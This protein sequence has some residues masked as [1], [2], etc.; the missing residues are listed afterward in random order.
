MVDERNGA[1]KFW[2]GWGS[3]SF[4]A[5][6]TLDLGMLAAVPWP[7]V[8][9]VTTGEA[10]SSS[11]DLEAR[12]FR[13]YAAV[14]SANYVKVASLVTL[15]LCVVTW[16]IDAW[17]WSEASGGRDAMLLVRT[18][19]AIVLALTHLG[20]RFV[21]L[22][23][24]RTASV[25]AVATVASC[26]I[27]A[28][29]LLP[30]STVADQR[31]L[32]WLYV[33]LL[34]P[35]FTVAVL[36]PL[37][38]RVMLNLVVA[39]GALLPFV[40]IHPQLRRI[41]MLAQPIVNL[42]VAAIVSTGVGHVGYR[43]VRINFHQR[44]QL[45]RRA[46]DLAHQDRARSQ[47]F[48]NV[49]HELRT[50]L[51]LVMTSLEHVNQHAERGD[52]EG[53][54]RAADVGLRNCA[55]LLYLVRQILELARFS[56]GEATA[57]RS[58]CD[59]ESLSRRVAA[60]FAISE[61]AF[62]LRFEGSLVANVD[63]RLV[64]D[65]LHNLLS[66]AVKFTSDGGAIVLDV[67][68]RGREIVVR[69]E[70]DGA[71]VAPN[72][73][74]RIFERHRQGTA[75]AN[76]PH[77]GTGIGLAYVRQVA[78][79][80]GGRVAVD[81]SCEQGARFVLVLPDAP[82]GER[83]MRS[84]SDA[85]RQLT[86]EGSSATG[87]SLPVVAD[88]APL[89]L[90]AEDHP[91]LAASLRRTLMHDGF[92]VL[93]AKDG[94]NALAMARASRPDLVLSDMMMPVMGGIEL[95]EALRDD[96]HL[97]D[98]PVVFLT[99][100][101]SDTLHVEALERGANDY[102][103]K[104]HDEAELLARV[105]NHVALRNERRALER[106]ARDL[107]FVNERLAQQVATK[108]S[109]VN[110]LLAVAT[111]AEGQE[112]HRVAAG[113]ERDLGRHLEAI[114]RELDL[115]SA[116]IASPALMLTT[117]SFIDRLCESTLEAVAENIRLL[118]SKQIDPCQLPGAIALATE[119]FE[120]RTGRRCEVSSLV[121]APSPSAASSIL[122]VV[123]RVLSGLEGHRTSVRLDMAHGARDDE[124]GVVA[125]AYFLD[126]GDLEEVRQRLVTMGASLSVSRAA[127]GTTDIRLEV[128]ASAP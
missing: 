25:I 61:R 82:A 60:R 117:L 123:Q 15:V 79:L 122:E 91:E 59:L 90:V 44:R 93:T 5:R 32:Q 128:G 80:H 72:E 127:D 113:L 62:T 66:N 6:A 39:F 21:P 11:D 23:T 8:K 51:T 116:R 67:T 26:V 14:T 112:R 77:G 68:R 118:R 1:S 52:R 71:G 40:L 49:S 33:V 84:G 30:V 54:A 48:A 121:A 29:G 16:P 87:D 115:A 31:D 17:W 102:V 58:R 111:S 78:E 88:D 24:A 37:R 104:P 12:A 43:L 36:V 65:A 42:L 85:P 22:S 13:D 108:L 101:A 3:K 41:S 4:D 56:A 63:E 106:L 94:S 28:L 89:V 83:T 99:A 100:R 96:Q 64:E 55:R 107:E 124:R 27:T 110:A 120:R 74:E 95:L 92:R 34:M 19:I 98:V 119:A 53:L 126:S 86:W 20:L 97:Q 57:R 9:G 103:V 69:V 38:G 45:T 114:R 73:V 18:G 109:S 76:S 7:S 70:D 35:M 47:F 10:A 81:L 46:D 50:P 105:R 125:G 75:A 2:A